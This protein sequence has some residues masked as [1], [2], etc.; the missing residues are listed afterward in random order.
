MNLH[1]T[2]VLALDPATR[3]TGVAYASGSTDTICC[4]VKLTGDDRLDW[5]AQAFDVLIRDE[6]PALVVHEAPFIHPRR[7]ASGIALVELHVKLRDVLRRRRVPSVVVPPSLLKRRATGK[8]NADK[9][10]MMAAA[11][12]LGWDGDGDDQ[13]DAWLLWHGAREG[14]W[15]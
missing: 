1:D 8:G 12:A 3:H 13:A 10:Q 6:R 14:W 5:W 7:P 11:R 9:A 4:P 2:R 15:A